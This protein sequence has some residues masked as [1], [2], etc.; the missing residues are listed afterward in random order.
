M[1]FTKLGELTFGKALSAGKDVINYVAGRYGFEEKIALRTGG[2]FVAKDDRPLYLKGG[3]IVYEYGAGSGTSGN[4]FT[5]SK[6]DYPGLRAVRVWAIGGGGSGAGAQNTGSGESSVGG[7]G[8]GAA[9]AESFI[10]VSSL[11]T[12]ETITVGGGGSGPT[13]NGNDGEDSSFG[14]HVVAMGGEGGVRIGAG[15]GDAASNN[16][17]PPGRLGGTTGDIRLPGQPG[18]IAVRLGGNNGAGSFSGMGGSAARGG[19]GGKAI[20]NAN[21]GVD[22][23]V[24][25]GGGSGAKNGQ[26]QPSNR[27]GGDGAHGVVVVELWY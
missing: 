23:Y 4:E 5:F 27:P 11:A 26:N 2:H 12:D 17:G 13:G 1:P 18:S 19:G 14:S 3:S 8:G 16:G 10:L 21:N 25:G 15:S 24:P 6:G 7:G 20:G 22:G 9:Y